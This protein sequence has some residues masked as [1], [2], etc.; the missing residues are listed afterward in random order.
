M[1]EEVT[2]AYTNKKSQ[3][4]EI[5]TILQGLEEFATFMSF[6]SHNGEMR[7]LSVET[8]DRVSLSYPPTEHT[9]SSTVLAMKPLSH[10]RK[11]LSFSDKIV[12]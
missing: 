12:H 7:I 5:R 9:T 10:K 3:E 4:M 1:T 8:V 11:S 2:M 6:N